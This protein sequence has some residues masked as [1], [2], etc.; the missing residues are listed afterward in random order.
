MALAGR[1]SRL[2]A[3]AGGALASRGRRRSAGPSLRPV[4]SPPA[5]PNTRSCRSANGYA[6]GYANGQPV[7]RTLAGGAALDAVARGA[8]DVALTFHVP[9]P[10]A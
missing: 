6:N 7:A 10:G 9:T 3:V 4:S 2:A 5:T 8:F 1:K